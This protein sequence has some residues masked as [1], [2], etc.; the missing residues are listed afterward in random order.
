MEREE[1]RVSAADFWRNYA[2]LLTKS[3]ISPRAIPWYRKR[4]EAYLQAAQG[5][6]LS[7]HGGADVAGFLRMIGGQAVLQDWQIRQTVDA[8]RILFTELVR[9]PW[10][11]QFDW[12]QWLDSARTLEAD[13][14]TTARDTADLAASTHGHGR[15]GKLLHAL[16]EHHAELAQRVIATLRV[17]GYAI[18]T[19]QAYLEWIARFLAFHHWQHPESLGAKQVSAF[20]EDL[21][22]QRKV[23]AST[24]HQALNAMVFLYRKVLELPLNDLQP[25][26]RAKRTQRVPTVLSQ[27]E[28]ARLLDAMQGQS[29]LMARLLYG[30]G[31]RLM[32]CIRL[33]VLDIDFSYGQITVRNGKGGK[34]RV[35][36][37]P[38]SLREPLQGHL[39]K[40]R[41][42]H[43][44]DLAAGMGSVYLPEALARKYPNAPKEWRWQYVFPATVLSVDPR[45]GVRRRHHLHETALQK[46]VRRACIDAGLVKRITCHTLRHSF[47]TH[48]L[49]AGSD[50]RTVQELLGHSDIKTTMIYTHVLGKGALAVGSPLDRL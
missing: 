41:E 44:A 32:E 42:L 40:V 15:G 49:E 45:S 30:S 7:H 11:R 34:D 28:V 27:A 48:M 8:L 35:V 21:A 33:R 25:F 4:I 3:G 13:H 1:T 2:S 24:Q 12:V 39:C 31:M 29:A 23:A 47:A 46:A 16:Q 50:I 10:A 19:E 43:D 36:P 14:P 38:R 37:L 9:A 26:T 22:L 18:R 6:R 20:L 5:K 17:G